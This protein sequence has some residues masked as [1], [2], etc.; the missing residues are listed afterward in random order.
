MERLSEFGI[1]VDNDL[2]GTDG[3]KILV[4]VDN[5]VIGLLSNELMIDFNG[6]LCLI[7]VPFA[8][9]I[10]DISQDA[11]LQYLFFGLVE[12]DFQFGFCLGVAVDMER[13]FDGG[14]FDFDFGLEGLDTLVVFIG[15]A[16]FE[17]VVEL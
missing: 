13:I 11:L 14:L 10:R 9:E 7:G 3:I 8:L 6:Q 17:L 4:I 5:D 16:E 12:R 2:I 1:G 15:Q